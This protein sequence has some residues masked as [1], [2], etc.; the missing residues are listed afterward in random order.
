MN[1]GS[2]LT[3]NNFHNIRSAKDIHLEIVEKAM[4]RY[5]ARIK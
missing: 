4:N 3:E 1:S 5:M 2:P